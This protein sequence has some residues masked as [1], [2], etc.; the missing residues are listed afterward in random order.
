MTDLTP[1][2]HELGALVVEFEHAIRSA[3]KDLDA[4]SY[5]G[6]ALNRARASVERAEALLPKL[7][8][9]VL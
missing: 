9:Q 6:A 8:Q 5:D 3:R 4:C 7:R 2:R 1:Q